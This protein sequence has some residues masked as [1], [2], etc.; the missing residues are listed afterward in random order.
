ML[1]N[2]LA[3]LFLK[4]LRVVDTSYLEIFSAF[5]DSNDNGPTSTIC[6]CGKLLDDI[7]GVSVLHKAA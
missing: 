1:I 6:K 3:D 2:K 7:F 5:G 4:F